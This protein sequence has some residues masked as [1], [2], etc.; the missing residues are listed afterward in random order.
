MGRLSQAKELGMW[1]NR[2]AT[3][4]MVLIMAA[5]MIAGCGDSTAERD[6]KE[7]SGKQ[8]TADATTAPADGADTAATMPA[9]LENAKL[10]PPPTREGYFRRYVSTGSKFNARGQWGSGPWASAPLFQGWSELNLE[11]GV[12][13]LVIP[14]EG[15]STAL[16][17][18]YDLPEDGKAKLELDTDQ[19][20]GYFLRGNK[21]DATAEQLLA[22][23]SGELVLGEDGQAVECYEL[24]GT[25]EIEHQDGHMV[26][27]RLPGRAVMDLDGD[28]WPPAVA[29]EGVHTKAKVPPFQLGSFVANCKQEIAELKRKGAP[30]DEIAMVEAYIASAY[31]QLEAGALYPVVFERL[32]FYTEWESEEA[33]RKRPWWMF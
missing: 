22:R 25:V 24:T 13:A 12:R 27:L 2:W 17:L 31:L 20:R 30:D 15:S 18:V 23:A 19:S 9:G 8:A 5:A 10:I 4:W 7:S 32:V 29:I 14:G 26:R 6:K 16:V 11:N 33:A 21:D 3:V 1:A 28:P